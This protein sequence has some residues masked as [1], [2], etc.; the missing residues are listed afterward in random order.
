VM[1]ETCLALELLARRHGTDLVGP[2]V[3]NIAG[4]AICDLLI[5]QGCAGLKKAIE[6]CL[7]DHVAGG[8]DARHMQHDAVPE[9]Y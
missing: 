4:G 6:G 2:V 5:W 9:N 1:S 8:V 3:P 7:T